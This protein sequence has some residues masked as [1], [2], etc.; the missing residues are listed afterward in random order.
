M[1]IFLY[2]KDEL[3]YD[4]FHV[5][6]EQ[7]FRIVQ[8]LQAGDMP[9]QTIG[10]S[11]PAMGEAFVKDIPEVKQFIRINGESVTIKK[12]NRVITENAMFVDSN[13][14]SA[15]SF[16]LAEGNKNTALHTPGSVV[17]SEEMARK[18]FDT[19]DAVGKV[20]QVKRID[21]FENFTVTG[22]A[23]NFPQNSS[24]KA[25]IFFPIQNN[26]QSRGNPWVGGSLNTFLLLSANAS[27]KTVEQKMQS[28]YE[29][30]TKEFTA[31]AETE[32]G[33]KF[34]ATLYLQPLTDIH[35]S[36]KAGPVNGM[37]DESNPLYSYILS[38]IAVLI[39]IIACI[40][41]VNLAVAES[42]KRSKEIGIRKVVGGS[43]KQ[44]IKQFFTESF[45]L[46]LISF[47][48]AIT[49][50]ASLL[51]FFN[52]LANKKLNLS[53]L[54]D[55]YLYGGFF[56]MLLVTTFISGFYPSLVLSAFQPVKV[57]Y[58][59]QR[60]MGRNYLTKGLIVLQF[61]VAIFLIIG[62]IAVYSQLNFLLNANLG[63]DSKN[64]VRVALPPG[65]QGDKLAA[66]FKNE[67]SNHPDIISVAARINGRNIS[68]VIANGKQI[69]IESNRVDD[70]Y[71]PAFKI[72]IIAGR[73]FSSDYPS[74][75]AKSVIVNKTFVIDAGWKLNEAVGK[76]II[77]MDEPKQQFTIVGVI[78]DYHFTSLKEKITPELFTM[79]PSTSYGE[80]WVKIDPDNI[81]EALY[82]IQNTF[83]K[84]APNYP[85]SYE[86]K[87]DIN[88][89]N[90]EAEEKWKKIISIASGLFIFISCMGLLG[91]VM[92]SIEHR[93]KEIGIRKVLGAAVSK[94]ILLISKEF[95]L[96]IAIASVIAIPAGYYF[97]NKW[98][99]DFAYRITMGWWMFALAGIIA[100]VTAMITVSL[101]A[102]KA[103]MANPVKCLRID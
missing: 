6:R 97:T 7:L 41:F 100:I 69:V 92:L 79:N 84:L 58:S 18:Y 17:I 11:T 15:F 5:N 24:I 36:K 32:Q 75:S 12:Y 43:R 26:L 66:L 78:R 63:Y 34:S 76:T 81:P 91:L 59:R 37:T 95:I 99:Q 57:L 60:L 42:L 55:G 10:I 16:P 80:I 93:T 77:S 86:F 45:L 25:G 68:G 19:D 28:L 94:I 27:I 46:S 71:L 20:L 51:P 1:L 102:L 4:R 44:V 88:A 31:K 22:V 21:S 9:P 96:L 39:L 82:A 85:Y 13:F 30:N 29:K 73:N 53:Y 14:F 72:P 74:D 101:Q 49:L 70:R 67:L 23:E 62:A 2:T 47:V 64:L 61:T 33:M 103:A 3:S 54:S 98:L 38:S 48:I 35:L 89:R 8:T 87:D 83:K 56:L 65:K 90:Y 52:E 50:T 40:N